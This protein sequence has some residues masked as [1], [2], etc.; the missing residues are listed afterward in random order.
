MDRLKAELQI[1]A[2]AVFSLDHLV[3]TR[4]RT[5][6]INQSQKLGKLSE[7]APQTQCNPTRPSLGPAADQGVF[8]TV[9]LWTIS[10]DTRSERRF[11]LHIAIGQLKV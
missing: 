4:L 7:C 10:P 8:R 2:R 3:R 6:T 11:D 5:A 1:D 9:T